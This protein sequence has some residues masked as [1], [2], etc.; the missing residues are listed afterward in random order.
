VQLLAALFSLT[1][2]C[3]RNCV[4]SKIHCIFMLYM[5]TVYSLVY[6]LKRTFW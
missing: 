5:H 6:S 4:K 2:C 1:S 3:M